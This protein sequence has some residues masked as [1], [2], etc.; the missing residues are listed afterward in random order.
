MKSI[1]VIIMTLCFIVGLSALSE[2]QIIDV[3]TADEAIEKSKIMQKDEQL[4]YLIEQ[5]EAF[6]KLKRYDDA[7]VIS[8]YV[9][10]NKMEKIDQE[11]TV[12]EAALVSFDLLTSGRGEAAK[13]PPALK[14]VVIQKY[15]FLKII[16]V[17]AVLWWVTSIGLCGCFLHTLWQRADEIGEKIRTMSVR[18]YQRL[19]FISSTFRICGVLFGSFS[20]IA[21]LT[22]RTQVA[23]LL[24]QIGITSAQRG[25]FL[26]YEFSIVVLGMLFATVSFVL[27][28]ITGCFMFSSPKLERLWKRN[29][30]HKKHA[31]E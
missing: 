29:K 13:I 18:A 8:H 12:D 22:L 11:G 15:R 1:F 23:N 5:A 28:T 2:A 25:S 3:A 7:L 17:L 30:A 14:M 27:M 16:A 6:Y 31:K 20:I 26:L 4:Q 10:M 9:I 21:A 24:T 19:Y